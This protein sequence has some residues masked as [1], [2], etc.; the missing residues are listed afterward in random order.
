MKGILMDHSKDA[1]IRVDRI[2]KSF[3]SREILSGVDFSVYRGEIF[4]LIGPSGVGKTTLIKILTGQLAPSKGDAIMFGRSVWELDDAFYASLGIVLDSLGLFERLTC[5]QNL[6]VFADIYGT[7]KKRI[8]EVLSSVGLSDCGKAKAYQL[9][10]GMRQRLALARA[11]LHRPRLLFLD[12]P[13]SGLDPVNAEAIHRLIRQ[14]RERGAT[15][16]LTTHKMEE[17]MALCDRLGILKDGSLAENDTPSRICQK[18]NLENRI[19]VTLKSGETCSFP[20]APSSAE[21]IGRLL[22]EN[23][24]ERIHSTEPDLETVFLQI[25]KG[26]KS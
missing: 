10:K 18:Y 5:Y 12:E 3:G 23:Q 19:V 20:N 8:A 16:F 14:E 21:E 11:V 9:S 22:R 2:C 4:G 13:T 26:G 25:A 6:S 1:V 7:E 17:A 15:V 24:M